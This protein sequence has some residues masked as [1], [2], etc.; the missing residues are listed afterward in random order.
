MTEMHISKRVLIML[1]EESILAPTIVSPLETAE[2]AVSVS[3]RSSMEN[4]KRSISRMTQAG[5]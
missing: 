3:E 5:R 2:I 4:L 1:G